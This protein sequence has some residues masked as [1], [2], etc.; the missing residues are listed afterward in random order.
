MWDLHCGSELWVTDGVIASLA[1]HPTERLLVIATFNELH[2]WDWSQSKPAIKIVTCNEREKV[3]Y[4]KFDKV[5]HQLITGIANL[6][7]M[8][9]AAADR[10]REANDELAGD[11]LRT[12]FRESDDETR[13]NMILDRYERI[14]ERYQRN[15][16]WPETGARRAVEQP[17][18]IQAAVASA[19]RAEAAQAQGGEQGGAG[20]SRLLSDIAANVGDRETGERPGPAARLGDRWRRERPRY[21]R[22]SLLLDREDLDTRG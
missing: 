12:R 9:S 3:R 2:F 21:M 22:Y 17:E 5:G 8:Q 15:L 7:P 20:A 6:T 4:V 1:F 16:E 14:M 10:A 18:L 19:A 11:M 13:Y